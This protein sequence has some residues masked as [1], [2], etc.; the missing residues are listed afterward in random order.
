M[1]F[2]YLLSKMDEALINLPIKGHCGVDPES[3]LGASIPDSSLN[4]GCV[5]DIIQ[6][7]ICVPRR[8]VPVRRFESENAGHA[9]CA[10]GKNTHDPDVCSDVHEGTSFRERE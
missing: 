9:A 8:T 2:L 1:D 7:H 3:Y 4:Q 6:K 10:V 5:R